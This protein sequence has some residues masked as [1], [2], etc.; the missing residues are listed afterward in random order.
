MIGRAAGAAVG[1]V[2]ALIA[3]A[4]SSGGS[5]SP[6]APATTA[7]PTATSRTNDA[8]SAT[9]TD[10][11]IPIEGSPFA[12]TN[13]NHVALP[14]KQYR[15]DGNEI[16]R[17]GAVT[18]PAIVGFSCVRCTGETTVATDGHDGTI[19]DVDGYYVGSRLINTYGNS[20]TS[21]ITVTAHGSWELELTDINS[22]EPIDAGQG[23]LVIQ[24]P[25][26]VTGAAITYE[27]SGPFAA[28]A[29]GGTNGLLAKSTGPYHG[30]VSLT[31][32]CLVQILAPPT[33]S[34]SLAL[35]S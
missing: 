2:V 3:A 17:V 31:G 11:Q 19:V 22:A 24:I 35:Q 20:V 28:E 30:T 6:T 16:V 32:P 29:Y 14:T 33:G 9:D 13:L 15:G 12:S 4:C 10:P 21:Q 1:V 25:K 23:D 27:G 7:P 8:S 5:P 18:Q 26:R 34:W